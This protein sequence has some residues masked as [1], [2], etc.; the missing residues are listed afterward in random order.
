MSD[1]CDPGEHSHLINNKG[2]DAADAAVVLSPKRWFVLLIFCMLSCSNN[3]QW[4][5]FANVV[6]QIQVYF[7]CSA[8]AVNWLPLI[9]N[10]IYVVGVFPVCYLYE[11][12][13]LRHGM[14]I[15]AIINVIGAG[16]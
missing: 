3:I 4:I 8:N 14:L 9:Y 10:L 2:S 12:L 6:R 1:D 15:G 16:L 11:R 7:D 5:I 13:G